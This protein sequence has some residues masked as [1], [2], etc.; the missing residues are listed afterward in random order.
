M[1]EM[2]CLFAGF[3]FLAGITVSTVPVALLNVVVFIAL[4]LA[5]LQVF[6]DR[7]GRYGLAF[8]LFG[9]F[10]ASFAWPFALAPFLGEEGC[11]GDQCMAWVFTT[12]G[13][14]VPVEE[15]QR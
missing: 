8:G 1:R 11:Q 15:A 10:F 7:L 13:A 2:G 14:K 6:G 9:A 3:T 4:A 12:P 5:M